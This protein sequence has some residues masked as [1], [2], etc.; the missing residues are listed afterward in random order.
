MADRSF[1]HILIA[2]VFF[3]L[4][5][6]AMLAW[7]L[8]VFENRPDS[9]L[10][11]PL[12][13]DAAQKETW[14]N[15]YQ[16]DRRIGY[17]HSVFQRT[18]TGYSLRENVFLRLNTMG[19]TQDLEMGTSARLLPDMT[20]DAFD[21][22]IASGAF[23]FS[24]TGRI[25][26]QAIRI[27]TDSGNPGRTVDIPIQERPSLSAVLIPGLAA[28]NLREGEHLRFSIFDPTAMAMQPVVVQVAAEETI[29]HRGQIVTA[30]KLIL[31]YRE[32]NQTAWIDA[33]GNVL[34][35]EGLLGLRLE[36]TSREDALSDI[37]REGGR[38][39]TLAAAVP[40]NVHIE[41]P[42][43]LE[44][45]SV[46][47]GGVH[48]E[49]QTLGDGRQ[50]Y[51]NG[52]LQIRKEFLGDIPDRLPEEAL[53]EEARALLSPSLFI[54]SDHPR[55]RKL[56]G[57]IVSPEDAVLIRISKI[58]SW[59]RQHVEKRPALSIP[60]AL[61]TLENRV[62]DCNEH[63]VLF[64]ALA[65][66]AGIPARVEAGLVYLNDRF[67]YHAWNGV[68][69]G[70]WITVD[71]LFGQFPAD[72]THLRFATGEQNLQ[73]VLISLLGRVTIRVEAMD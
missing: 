37:P 3:G 38:D 9:T 31:Q 64:A 29:S 35:E 14:M 15:V 24:A 12:A 56:I 42:A 34:R 36:N 54:Q 22:R 21:F 20:L 49:G 4:V 1:R 47:I 6:L 53:P 50:S 43:G 11:A 16:N 25:V 2:G 71:P 70:R 41:A 10:H 27:T 66:A 17:S 40:S 57:E 46:R 48:L 44:T 39:L 18:E 68:Y 45:L 28:R 19:L 13:G 62:G 72:V 63:A 55:F 23:R 26:D 67:Y 33:Q 58:V 32:T 69:V 59:I 5:F 7:R 73:A 8:G 52:L 61:A 51:S 65:R 30:R 60:D